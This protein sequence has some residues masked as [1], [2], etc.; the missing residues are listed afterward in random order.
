MS[1]L[2][3][4]FGIH[5]VFVLL[6]G[7]WPIFSAA[8]SVMPVILYFPGQSNKGKLT[9]AAGFIQTCFLALWEEKTY[10]DATTGNW[11]LWS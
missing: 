3:F 2:Q 10:T 6:R 8:M 4:N 1:L 5:S 9:S 7:D 11:E